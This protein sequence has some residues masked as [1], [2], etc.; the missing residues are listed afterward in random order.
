MLFLQKQIL[1]HVHFTG[2]FAALSSLNTSLVITGSKIFF[3]WQRGTRYYWFYIPLKIFSSNKIPYQP[4]LKHITTLN[5]L[6]YQ[7]GFN[8]LWL[9]LF[10]LEL[11]CSWKMSHKC[12]YTIGR[13]SCW[14]QW[15]LFSCTV[16]NKQNYIWL[17]IPV[18]HGSTFVY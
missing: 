4:P 16:L 2:R 11:Q 9:I 1:L 14:I 18:V 13:L 8:I 7:K 12:Y 15:D 17:Y 3:M 5:S 6:Q 10:C